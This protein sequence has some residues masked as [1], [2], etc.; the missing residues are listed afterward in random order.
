MDEPLPFKEPPKLMTQTLNLALTADQCVELTI[1]GLDQIE[2]GEVKLRK[3]VADWLK[4]PDNGDL[5][6]LAEKVDLH[7]NSEK[8][9]FD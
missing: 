9:C 1:Q 6:Q 8:S 5:R 7:R 4:D 3:A 2:A